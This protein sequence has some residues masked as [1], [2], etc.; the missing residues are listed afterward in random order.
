M[1][2]SGRAPAAG[3][4]AG[5][6]ALA[7]SPRSRSS[8]LPRP[9]PRGGA[10]RTSGASIPQAAPTAEQFQRLHARR[11]RQRPHPDRLGRRSRRARAAPPR[12]GCHRRARR[13]ARRAPASKCCRSSPA[14][15]PGRCPRSSVNAAAIARRPRNLP[16]K[17]AGQK[18]AWAL[19][20]ATGGRA[21]TGPNGAFWAENPGSPL[22]A[23]PHLADLERGELQI[24]RRPAQPGRIREAGEALLPRDQRRSTRAPRW[25]SAGM[26]VGAERGGSTRRSR[27]RPISPPNSSTDVQDHA[28]DQDRSSTASPC[29]RTRTTGRT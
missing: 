27:H 4:R 11:R 25:S 8:R 3:A 18:A 20:P 2:N 15:P 1:S 21:A 12:L 9:R 14:R 7:G 17:T 28:G 6:A 24:L 10:R 26:F 5:R 29:T 23:D 19:L 22:P 13:Q 16:V